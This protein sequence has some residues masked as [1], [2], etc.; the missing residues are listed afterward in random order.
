MGP[1]NNVCR[2]VLVLAGKGSPCVIVFFLRGFAASRL[3]IMGIG[4]QLG[5]HIGS[6]SA[7]GGSGSGGPIVISLGVEFYF[8]T[9][10]TKRVSIIHHITAR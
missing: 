2:T 6:T 1:E 3:I 8:P 10:D 9:W 7:K 4:S 5:N